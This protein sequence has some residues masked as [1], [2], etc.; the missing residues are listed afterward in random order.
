MIQLRKEHQLVILLEV[1]Q[2]TNIREDLGRST[3][4]RE[5]ENILV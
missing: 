1:D 4:D 3:G 2:R 5:D